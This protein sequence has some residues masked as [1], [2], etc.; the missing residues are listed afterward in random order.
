M[1]V[2]FFDICAP[3]CAFCLMRSCAVVEFVED[4]ECSICGLQ[5]E[6][7]HTSVVKYDAMIMFQP[8]VVLRASN[9]A[10]CETLPAHHQMMLA[11]RKPLNW[12][13]TA[14]RCCLP[15]LTRYQTAY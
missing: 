14:R 2:D 9:H 8:P 15:C 10:C 4:D 13:S 6:A 1:E 5:V 12:W 7:H 3:D 11:E